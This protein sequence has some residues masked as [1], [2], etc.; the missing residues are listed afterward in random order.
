M[1][2]SFKFFLRSSLVRVMVGV[3]VGIVIG[4]SGC[5]SLNSLWQGVP[6][7]QKAILFFLP[8]ACENQK[9]A[10]EISKGFE[11]N[12]SQKVELLKLDNF[13]SYISSHSVQVPGYI[14]K[15]QVQL[16][17]LINDLFK[18]DDVRE[19]FA[20]KTGIDYLVVGKAK[21]QKQTELELGN[22]VTAETAEVRM[23]EL[24]T[25]EILLDEGFKQGLFEI[26]TPDRIGKKL[27]LKVNLRL[28]QVYRDFQLNQRGKQKP[29][30]RLKKEEWRNEAQ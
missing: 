7:P 27:A 20:E 4:F 23:L 3:V 16:E 14:E 30:Y 10:D 28:D 19:L 11:E 17:N 6:K 12:L 29:K 13:G 2:L 24:R 21:E 26:V 1:K 9:I 18:K 25:G 5:A 15:G 22:V 8:F